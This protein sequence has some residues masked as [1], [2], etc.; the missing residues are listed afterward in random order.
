M[1]TTTKRPRKALAE[2]NP[3][4]LVNGNIP[5][6]LDAVPAKKSKKA[7]T[8]KTKEPKISAASIPAFLTEVTLPGEQDVSP[9]YI[10]N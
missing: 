6:D 5:E 8:S 1:P 7:E 2:A 10:Q 4:T 9:A 3:D